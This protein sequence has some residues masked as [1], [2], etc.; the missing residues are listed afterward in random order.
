VHTALAACVA[1][2]LERAPSD[3]YESAEAFGV[4]IAEAAGDA[5][6]PNSLAGAGITVVASGAIAQALHSSR[7]GVIAP[8]IGPADGVIAPDPPENAGAGLPVAARPRPRRVPLALAGVVALVALAAIA[9]A[10]LLGGGG[11]EKRPAPGRAVTGPAV[12]AASAWRALPAA[13][14]ARQQLASAVVGG[15]I[16]LAGGLGSAPEGPRATRAV[17]ALDPA[18]KSWKAGPPLP[19]PLN[20]SAGATYR[21]R[22]VVIGGWLPRGDDVSALTVGRVY[23]LNGRRW[24]ALPPL[25]HPRA[26]AAAATASG[27]LVVVGGQADDRLVPSTD[28]FDGH[29]WSDGAP[30][31]TPREHLAAV[32]DGR[33]VYA[34][35]GRRLS[36]SKNLATLE[37][38]DPVADR[39]QRL[40][41]MPA[42]RGGFGAAVVGGNLIAA[43]GETPTGALRTVVS[44]NFRSRK[45][46][47]LA[48]L[49]FA[50]HG[51]AVT[52]VGRSIYVIGGGRRAGHYASTNQAEVLEL[53]PATERG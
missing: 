2:A 15:Q 8:T 21:G 42:P 45:W 26:A 48:P 31:P 36:S 41:S 40:P 34:I 19:V 9:G 1:R 14:T 28:V 38:Y 20:H 32:S 53:R 13:P 17:E 25:R 16:W 52:A 24:G 5:W 33:Y 7:G 4:A 27:R 6:G 23:T 51:E 29:R 43:G 10:V 30:I 50:V 11:E 47:S 12:G 39:W 35:G 44:Y 49:P 22:F 46:S 3:R 18:I 37:R